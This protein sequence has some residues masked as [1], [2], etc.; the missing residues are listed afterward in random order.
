[1]NVADGYSMV[2]HRQ[3]AE[4]AA[5]QHGL[6]TQAQ[7][8]ELGFEAN[9]V[10]RRVR[11]GEWVRVLPT[12]YRLA[13]VPPSGRQGALAATLWAGPGATISHAAAGVLWG[14]GGVRATGVELWVPPTRRVRSELVVVHRG[15]VSDRDRRVIDGIPRTSVPRTIVDLAGRLDA[16]SLDAAV[17][18]VVHRGLTTFGS[19]RARADT[20][21]GEKR[22]GV[23]LLRKLLDERGGGA[24]AES[25]LETRVRRALHG[26]GLR[27]V[28]QHEVVV[29]GGRRYRLD[30]AWPDLRVAVEPDGYSVHGRR[31]AFERDRRRWADLTAAGWRIIPVTWAQ[32]TGRP[33]EFLERVQATLAAAAGP[34]ASHAPRGGPAYRE[35]WPERPGP[36]GRERECRSRATA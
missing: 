26:A 14:I 4:L 15:L 13:A 32:V 34:E 28:G 25:R 24:A 16:E 20:A 31:G 8:R 36:K 33:V 19:L 12:V 23:P 11:A 1:M 35:P 5:R 6:V 10:A 2:K 7:A 9:A 30:F 18:D 22:S 27:P 29:A 3:L 17:D 21:A